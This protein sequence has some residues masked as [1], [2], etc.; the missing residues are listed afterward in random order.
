ME[1]GEDAEQGGVKKENG[2]GTGETEGGVRGD[3]RE[4]KDWG[5]LRGNDVTGAN[6]G[7]WVG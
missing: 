4:K 1:E 2:I 3:L 6:G 7:I 5:R